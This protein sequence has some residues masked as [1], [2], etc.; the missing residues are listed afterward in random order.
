ME[1]LHRGNLCGVS[2]AATTP[3]GVWL[4]H[5]SH[6]CD[7]H[8]SHGVRPAG[9]DVAGQGSGAGGSGGEEIPAAGDP[10]V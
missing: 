5:L 6:L 10:S 9:S 7:F 1:R 3:A 8:E 4:P 2:D